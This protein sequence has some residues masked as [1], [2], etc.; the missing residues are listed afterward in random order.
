MSEVI[1]G[2]GGKVSIGV[3][4][5]SMFAGSVAVE[6]FGIVGFGATSMTD[7]IVHLLKK[8]KITKGINARI[9]DGQIELDFHL[10]ISYGVNIPAVIDNLTETVTYRVEKFSGMKLKDINIFIEGVRVID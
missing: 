4:V 7:G 2:R 10:I 5:I 3:D 6:C 9:Q 1:N 8:E